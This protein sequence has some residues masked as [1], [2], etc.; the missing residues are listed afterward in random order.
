[1]S[2]INSIKISFSHHFPIKLL[3]WCI[4]PFISRNSLGQFFPCP[5][6][7]SPLDNCFEMDPI[8]GMFGC[9]IQS[10]GFNFGRGISC[11]AILGNWLNVKEGMKHGSCNFSTL[12]ASSPLL[13]W[14][15]IKPNI[16]I[17]PQCW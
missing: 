16:N 15:E 4:L 10:N 5:L 3:N 2:T 8:G 9:E 17:P 11:L 1:M 6:P 14:R 13:D 12:S 7:I